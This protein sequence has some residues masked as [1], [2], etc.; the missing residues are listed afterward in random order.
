[1]RIHENTVLNSNN[2]FALSKPKIIMND[3][4]GT[5][6]AR[7]RLAFFQRHDS[8]FFFISY[9]GLR[10]RARLP[11]CFQFRRWI[12]ATVTHQLPLRQGV[13]A[14]YEPDGVTP[15]DPSNVPI[16]PISAT[17]SSSYA[18]PNL[19]RRLVRQ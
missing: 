15:I 18:T 9:E 14:I 11:S 19:G 17:C 10:Y 7:C 8:T 6:G 1:L 13:S 4:G 5:L 2:T 12:C 16:T 3:F